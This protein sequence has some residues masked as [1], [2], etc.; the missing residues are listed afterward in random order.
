[1]TIV[2]YLETTCQPASGVSTISNLLNQKDLTTLRRNAIK[3]QLPQS[4]SRNAPPANKSGSN[5]SGSNSSRPVDTSTIE[6]VPVSRVSGTSAKSRTTSANGVTVT[7][8]DNTNSKS[9]K[10]TKKSRVIEISDP[11]DSDD[12]LEREAAL[13]SPAKG[14]ESRNAT[15]VSKKIIIYVHRHVLKIRARSSR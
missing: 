14:A 9:K 4:N 10:P 3:S 6:S 11:E 1:M 8:S 5:N 7:R 13:A 15:K 2:P 12:S